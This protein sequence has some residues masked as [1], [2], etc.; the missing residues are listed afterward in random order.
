VAFDLSEEQLKITESDVGAMFPDSYRLYMMRS[1]G[2]ACSAKSD[3]WNII[4][5]RDASDRKRLSRTA[6][7]VLIETKSFSEFPNWHEGAFAIAEN[8]TGDA[9]VMFLKDMKFEPQIFYW[10][11]ENGSLELVAKDFADLANGR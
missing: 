8:G 7:H 2:G 3:N 4:P 5:I 1:N 9:L 10:R 6:N 11:H